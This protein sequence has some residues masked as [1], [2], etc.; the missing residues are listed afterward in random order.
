MVVIMLNFLLVIIEYFWSIE[1]CSRGGDFLSSLKLHS[2][3]I[4]LDWYL[5]YNLIVAWASL[6]KDYPLELMAWSTGWLSN[7]CKA[8]TSGNQTC[9][10]YFKSTMKM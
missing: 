2:S 8:N 10:L 5:S 1:E 7:I 4:L 3:I 9:H 6:G